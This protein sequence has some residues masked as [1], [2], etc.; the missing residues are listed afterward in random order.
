MRRIALLTHPGAGR[1]RGARARSVVLPRLRDAGFDVVDLVGRDVDEARRLAG[2]AVADGVEAL[3]ACGGDGTVHLALQHVVPAG[4]PLGVVPAGTGNDLARELGLPTAPVAAADRIIAGPRRTLDVARVGD[5]YVATVVACGFDALVAER[6]DAMTWPRGPLRYVAA[7]AVELRS[8]APRRY[9]LELD[10][11]VR[12]VEGVLAAV[13][14]TSS[15]GG[16]LR[17]TEGAEPDDGLLDVVVVRS[18]DRRGLVRAFPHLY[19]GTHT[20]H[21]A[22]E[23]HRVRSA[24]I[25]A[26]DITAYADGEPLGSLPLTVTAVPAALTVIA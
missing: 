23:H 18:L 15:F 9:T 6:A 19:R 10:G 20:T 4:I 25:A 21:P 7:T 26:A 11:R 24:T 17:I 22:Y 1:G 3:V 16:G 14:N 5:R 2:A 8:L 12:T 13:G